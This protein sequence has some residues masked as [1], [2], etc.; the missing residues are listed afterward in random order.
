MRK[1]ALAGL[2][3]CVL[4]AAAHSPKVSAQSLGLLQVNETNQTV[5]L[6]APRL[7][8]T[9]DVSVTPPV[10]PKAPEAN[11]YTVVDGDS[12]SKIAKH[13]DTTWKRLFDKNTQLQ[14]PDMLHVGDKLTIPAADEK[15]AERP[16]PQPPV[17]VPTAAPVAT[18]VRKHT[19]APRPRSSVQ[20][21]QRRG[22][23]SGNTYAPGYCTWY[24]KNRRPDLPNNLGNADTWFARAAAQGYATGYAPR[25]G[26]IGQRGMHVVYVERVNGDGTVTVSEMNYYGLYV[27]SSRT[28]PASYFVYIY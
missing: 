2:F 13:Y 11:T 7:P 27:V 9:L 20:S 16:L 14:N 3:A 18:P 19:P 15:L 4:I 1:S 23:V 8:E 17:S 10:V 5:A 25:A 22:Y 24:A 12:L 6:A 21:V 28:V 26:A